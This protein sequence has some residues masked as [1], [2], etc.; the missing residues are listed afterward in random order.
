MKA[1][2]C[3]VVIVLGFVFIG[4]IGSNRNRQ[5]ASPVVNTPG[6]SPSPSPRPLIESKPIVETPKEM[7]IDD[8]ERLYEGEGYVY[9]SNGG[10]MVAASQELFDQ[11]TECRRAGDT[12]GMTKMLREKQISTLDNGTKVLMIDKGIFT[13]RIRILSGPNATEEGFVVAGTSYEPAVLDWMNEK[14]A[15]AAAIKDEA[16]RLNAEEDAKIAEEKRTE[17][18]AR[19]ALTAI[20]KL[21]K[22]K[23]EIA[24]EKLKELVSKYPGTA[25]A[26]KAQELLQK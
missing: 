12:I 24:K 3:L 22:T 26:A 9:S 13:D 25:A 10:I 6:I 2:G 21:S 5:V 23:P 1:L 15:A 20:E 16:A 18:R 4:L 11:A 8:F 19:D 17:N 7:T 14:A